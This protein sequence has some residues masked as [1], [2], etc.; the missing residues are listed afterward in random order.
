MSF[1]FALYTLV[2]APLWVSEV[3][4]CE[5]RPEDVLHVQ[6][7]VSEPREYSSKREC[8]NEEWDR[9]EFRALTANSQG[10][11]LLATVSCRQEYEA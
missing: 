4:V 6:C 2:G 10:R 5:W 1:L 11:R 9:I 3:R 8:E 7:V